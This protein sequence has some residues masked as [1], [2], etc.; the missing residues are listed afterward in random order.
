MLRSK[1]FL[2]VTRP[3]AFI[4][5]GDSFNFSLFHSLNDTV[6][7][8]YE[9]LISKIKVQ[10]RIITF[11][12]F[13]SN[14]HSPPQELVYADLLLLKVFFVPV[15]LMVTANLIKLKPKPNKKKIL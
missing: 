11:L 3:I 10:R 12:I 15:P 14:I 7:A 2:A 9:S 6:D 13:L 5:L 8:C 4:K 1:H